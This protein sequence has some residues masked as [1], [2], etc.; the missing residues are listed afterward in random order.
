MVRPS[1]PSAQV[2]VV[3]EQDWLKGEGQTTKQTMRISESD[4][5]RKDRVT[6]SRRLAIVVLGELKVLRNVVLERIH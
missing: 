5:G 6:I 1:E 2:V 4:G 3:P